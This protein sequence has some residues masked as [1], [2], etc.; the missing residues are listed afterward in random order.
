MFCIFQKQAGVSAALPSALRLYSLQVA[1]CAGILVGVSGCSSRT[2][3]LDSPGKAAP[4][5][6]GVTPLERSSEIDCRLLSPLQCRAQKL[7][8]ALE[9]GRNS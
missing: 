9:S 8:R 2:Q 5:T 1:I 4:D 7:R 3:D 6:P